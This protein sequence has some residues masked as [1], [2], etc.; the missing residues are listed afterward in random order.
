SRPPHRPGPAAVLA[1]TLV[2][3]FVRRALAYPDDVAAA[4][5]L[6]GV[7][8]YRKLL[9]GARL[10]ARRFSRLP[11]NAVGVLL[12]SSVAADVT[13]FALHLAGKLPVLLNWTT[14]P[15][16]LAHAV[17]TLDIHRVITSQK[18]I[19][20]LG[21]EV[22]GAEFV[23][24]EDLRAGVGKLEAAMALVGTHVLPRRMITRRP[25][26]SL[27]PSEPPHGNGGAL[28]EDAP[29]VVLFTSGSESTPKAVPLSHRNLVTN[30]RASL[31]VLKPN[32]DDSMLAILPP[33]HSFGLLGN[34]VAPI[35]GGIRVVHHSDPTDARG[36]LRLM[37]AYRTTYLVTTPT[38]LS[39]LLAVATPADLQSL[40]V[41]V[42]GAEK[43]PEAIF[44]RAKELAPQATIIEGYGITECS[45]VV[46]A[47]RPERVRPG[48]V[49]QP[50]EGVE[51]LVVDPET[52][53]PLP[54]GT[55]GLLLVRG[56]SVFHGYLNYDGPDPFVQSGGRQWY[57]T[58][59]LVRLDEDGYIHFCGRLKRFL[60]AGGEMI[61]LVALEE[62]FASLYPPTEQGPQVA[63][64][65][66][67]TPQGR[68]IVLFTT[69]DIPLRQANAIL[70][71]AGFRGVMRLDEV[72]R[73]P[74]I[75]VLGTG[76]TDYKA[77]RKMVAA[78]E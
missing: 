1:E 46:A 17:R 16:N 39:Y 60:K 66:I 58:G 35:L 70:S 57:V 9:V 38:F 22:P 21:I 10:M 29:A 25:G 55:T 8:S 75:P 65:G 41:I 30:A 5:Q 71:D 20:R 56:P 15:A 69:L 31:D 53:E 48:T 18:L 4:D 26:S 36:Q 23:F 27:R 24:L 44:A 64:E 77:L 72:V 73:L 74:S 62:P 49:G 47:N 11:D 67:E 76:K 40:R 12:P 51:V 43:C 7:L 78:R 59:D 6:S 54:P 14:G 42:T 3:A 13:F 32:P 34:V 37:A 63:V 50:V 52:R 33:F 19:D 45:P 68:L 28:A 61:S 2:E